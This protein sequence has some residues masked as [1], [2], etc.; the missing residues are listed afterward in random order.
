MS[1]VLL[2][3]LTGCGTGSDRAD[4]ADRARGSCDEADPAVVKEV[5]SQARTDYRPIS[6]DGTPDFQ[7]DH[8]EMLASGSVRL[9]E[10]SREHGADRLLAVLVKTVV[11]GDDASLG[12]GSVEDVVFFASDAKG[13]L[14]GPVGDHTASRFEIESPD[15]PE[16][17]AWAEQ[18][19][20]LKLAFD[21]FKCL[22][23]D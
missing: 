8:L 10:T 1:I 11:G 22:Q 3:G 9:P 2:A 19:E 5:M 21:L 7:I 6:S 16:W 20:D 17:A 4:R 14:L 12:S 15:D 23:P 18:T 13:D